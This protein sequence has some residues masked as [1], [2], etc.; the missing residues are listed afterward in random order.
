MIQFRRHT[1]LSDLL[2]NRLPPAS[3]GSPHRRRV[4]EAGMTLRATDRRAPFT[5]PSAVALICAF[6][7][8]AH[9]SVR[10]TKAAV[11]K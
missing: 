2:P 3:S 9:A 4:L 5:I 11:L 7:G 1:C 6:A 8:S 10:N